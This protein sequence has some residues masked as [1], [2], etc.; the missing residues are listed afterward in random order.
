MADI[1]LSQAVGEFLDLINAGPAEYARAYRI[2]MRGL[3]NLEWDVSGENHECE[4][5]VEC[6]MTVNLPEDYINLNAIGVVN[7][8]GE[9][10]ALTHNAN[11]T[12]ADGLRQGQEYHTGSDFIEEWS[13]FDNYMAYNSSSSLGV[14]SYPNIGEYREDRSQNIIILNP[15]FCYNS[16]VLRY[17]RRKKVKGDYLIN[18]LSVDALVAYMDW[19]W[20]RSKPGVSYSD[21]MAKR[22]EWFN[23]KRL[24]KSRIKNT[25]LQKMSQIARQATRQ[26]LKG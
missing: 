12:L 24:A 14:G 10:A 11:L 21:R 19:Q 4:L 5:P 26:G 6:D 25:T 17:L 18:E 22:Q 16:V 7:S 3:R 20:H 2:A 23:E 13:K 1:K 8:R 9:L 15:D